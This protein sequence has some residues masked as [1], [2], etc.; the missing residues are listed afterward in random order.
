MLWFNEYG[1]QWT[2]R[3]TYQTMVILLLLLISCATVPY[4]KKFVGTPLDSKSTV[5]PKESFPSLWEKWTVQLGAVAGSRAPLQLLSP[6]NITGGMDRGG[7]GSEF[8]L[9]ITATLM[10]SMLIEAGL[11]HYS[12]LI[13]MTPE[14]KEEFR[15]SY[16]QHY[17]VENH[18][19]IWCEMQTFWSELY[20]DP[21]RWIIFI[22]DDA[23]NQ[24]EP[25]QILEE[26]N[27][28]PAF[29]QKAKDSFPELQ[30]EEIKSRWETH[31]KSLMLCFPRRD[32]LNN[33]VLSERG[34]FLKLVFQLNEDEKVRAEGIWV[35]KE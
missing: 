18:L 17:D 20:L 19:L 33:P 22:Q 16:F 29:S 8:P 12:N 25:L 7:G 35:F 31:S 32:F 34:R 21:K 30:P 1:A 28:A 13:N 27:K 15:N 26:E 11:Q 5:Q 3:A 9:L 2:R 14:E 4:S 6:F 24:Y 10:D 23:G